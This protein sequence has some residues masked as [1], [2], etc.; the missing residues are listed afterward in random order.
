MISPSTSATTV[1][2]FTSRQSSKSASVPGSSPSP[3]SFSTPLTLINS[4]LKP[5]PN[6]TLF[7]K[8]QEP[9]VYYLRPRKDKLAS[10]DAKAF[11]RGHY[12][13]QVNQASNI[14]SDAHKRVIAAQA[15]S[16][17]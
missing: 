16:Q 14:L 7:N 17:L 4:I 2:A 13:D 8:P 15:I 10:R 1:A 9:I 11:L 12:P 5:R 6:Y 3:N